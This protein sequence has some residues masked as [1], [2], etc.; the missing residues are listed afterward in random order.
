MCNTE[1]YTGGYTND[2]LHTRVLHKL[3]MCNTECYT[4]DY[5]NDGLHTR[6]TI[7]LV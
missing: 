4:G 3:G 2:G 7:N 1:C 6:N 5:T